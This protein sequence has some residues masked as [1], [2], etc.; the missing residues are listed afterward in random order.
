[1]KLIVHQRNTINDLIAT[2]TKYG[3][4]VDIRSHGNELVI[5]HDPF[6]DGESF[7]DWLIE[8]QHGTLVLNV[9]E[10][11]L[12]GRLIELMRIHD[13]ADYF[14]LDQSFPFLLRWAKASDR[15]CAVRVSEFENVETALSLSSKIGWAWVD[16]F[17][18]FSLSKLDA[19]RLKNSGF[20]LCIVSPELHGRNPEIEIPQLA[21]VLV[22]RSI[23]ADAI[24]TKRPDLWEIILPLYE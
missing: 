8:Y 1:M 23:K 24:C 14:L 4:E 3:I 21:N 16:C 19:L 15:R 2:N 22:E 5:H 20:R 13:I 12:E 7:E 9:K 17:S 11:G 10:E 6:I 18:H